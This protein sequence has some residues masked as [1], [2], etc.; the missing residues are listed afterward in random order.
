M[1][2][3]CPPP[4]P[5]GGVS[6]ARPLLLSPRQPP[7]LFPGLSST[8]LLLQPFYRGPS[9]QR[10]LEDAETAP[11][12]GIAAFLLSTL[13][14]VGNHYV[15]DSLNASGYVWGAE[16]QAGRGLGGLREPQQL[17]A[18]KTEERLLLSVTRAKLVAGSLQVRVKNGDVF[19]QTSESCKWA[20]LSILYYTC[21]FGYSLTVL[22]SSVL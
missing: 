18:A 6:R 16:C 3:A 8:P 21:I 20:S 17:V 7:P 5:L 4:P 10:R 14:R 1:T 11:L 13:I 22:G 15:S 19:H 9:A 2:C 12:K